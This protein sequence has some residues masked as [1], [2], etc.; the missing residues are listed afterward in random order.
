MPKFMWLL[1]DFTLQL[2]GHNNK[3][4]SANEYMEQMIQESVLKKKNSDIALSIQSFFK[5]R[6]C[7][8]MRRPV[9]DEKQ[10]KN[11]SALANDK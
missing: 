9:N 8:V 5:D 6:L 10:V 7:M 4:A 1:R 3:D 11:L 2:K